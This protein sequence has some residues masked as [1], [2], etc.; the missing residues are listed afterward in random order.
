[1]YRIIVDCVKRLHGLLYWPWPE[2]PISHP[3]SIHVIHREAWWWLASSKPVVVLVHSF[4]VIHWNGR[5]RLLQSNNLEDNNIAFTLRA[6]GIWSHRSHRPDKMHRTHNILLERMSTNDFEAWYN[7]LCKCRDPDRSCFLSCSVRV[8]NVTGVTSKYV[9][10][11]W[12]KTHTHIGSHCIILI[13]DWNL[14][15][16]RSVLYHSL[17]AVNQITGIG[18]YDDIIHTALYMA[19]AYRS[20]RPCMTHIILHHWVW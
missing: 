5:H 4:A 1:M 3:K 16:I 10:L 6:V 20:N 11:G 19:I 13:H 18:L 9:V 17:P 7:A 12:F 14:Y 15:I 8:H 2:N